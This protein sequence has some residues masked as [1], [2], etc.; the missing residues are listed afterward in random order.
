[1]ATPDDILFAPVNSKW[2]DLTKEVTEYIVN[3]ADNL[4]PMRKMFDPTRLRP[5][6]ALDLMTLMELY[7]DQG[8][9]VFYYVII[10]R[11]VKSLSELTFDGKIIFGK[12]E[13]NKIPMLSGFTGRRSI[14]DLNLVPNT[15][16]AH[17]VFASES[18]A[19]QYMGSISP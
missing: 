14:R 2:R 15:Y 10:S 16:T 17:F 7:H 19:R 1:M 12:Y 18:E 13:N 8:Q 9:R 11:N 4:K 3:Q 6:G 5:Q